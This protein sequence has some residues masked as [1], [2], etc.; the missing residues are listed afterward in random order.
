MPQASSH[1]AALT[2]QSVMITARITNHERKKQ[3]AKASHDKAPNALNVYS[4]EMVLIQNALY[5]HCKLRRLLVDSP[6]NYNRS[7]Y[8]K[9]I[10]KKIRSWKRHYER[11]A[12]LSDY[13]GPCPLGSHSPGCLLAL[14]F[15]DITIKRLSKSVS[16]LRKRLHVRH[17]KQL[18]IAMSQRVQM[19]EEHRTSRE[20][21]KLIQKLGCKERLNIDL[22]T[23]K[24]NTGTIRT[25]P[26]AVSYTH[27]T[28]PT[29]L[30][31]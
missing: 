29:I 25:S 4:P 20:F 28:L 6:P 10:A 1:L 19:L 30:R 17:R 12:E 24:D 3:T 9:I 7:T 8:R 31:V 23:L 22:S 26:E 16:A 21:G 13:E 14:S 15:E 5:T 2:R 11:Y 27:L 18:R